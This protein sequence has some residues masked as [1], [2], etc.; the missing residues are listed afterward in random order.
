MSRDRRRVT[1]S[2]LAGLDAEIGLRRAELAILERARDTLARS[3][4]CDCADAA[5]T[6][7][8]HTALCRVCGFVARRCSS[9]G[10]QRA[11]N[12]I[13]RYHDHERHGA[14]WHGAA[15]T[16]DAGAML[17]GGEALSMG[18]VPTPSPLDGDGDGAPANEPPDPHASSES[19]T[20]G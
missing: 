1:E 19:R 8:I 20:A 9:H 14:A 13:L 17:R 16:G 5:C 4:G 6:P 3:D 11:A 12:A 7:T 18:R 15:Q 10:G 2:A